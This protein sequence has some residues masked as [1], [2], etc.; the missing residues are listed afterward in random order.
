MEV[1]ADSVG[2]MLLVAMGAET[3]GAGDCVCAPLLADAALD[4]ESSAEG[5]STAAVGLADAVPL[6]ASEASALGLC[7]AA[8]LPEPPCA[9]D[10]VAAALTEPPAA[11]LGVA[12][13]DCEVDAHELAEPRALPAA[14]LLS[15]GLELAK[16]VALSSAASE[17][18]LLADIVARATLF[19][20][21]TLAVCAALPVPAA[22]ALAV[23]VKIGEAVS[24]TLEEAEPLTSAVAERELAAGG[25]GDGFVEADCAGA[26][27]EGDCDAA[28]GEPDVDAVAESSPELAE[29]DDDALASAAVPVA[30]AE[31]DRAA[32]EVCEPAAVAL[33]LSVGAGEMLCGS[34]WDAEKVAAGAVAVRAAEVS[35]EAVAAVG[36]SVAGADGEELGER[37]AGAEAESWEVPVAAPAGGDAEVR[38]ELDARRGESLGDCVFPVG[39]NVAGALANPLI[40]AALGVKV[41]AST[42]LV[43]AEAV[44]DAEPRALTLPQPLADAEAGTGVGDAVTRAGVAEAA[45]DVDG[46]VD[47]DALALASADSEPAAEGDGAPPDALAFALPL[48]ST[49]LCD[50][51][52]ECEGTGE[53]VPAALGEAAP[54]SDCVGAALALSPAALAEAAP[55]GLCVPPRAPE[56]DG[57]LLALP[58][59]PP[60][61]PPLS[62]GGADS[63]GEALPGPLRLSCAEADAQPLGFATDADGERLREGQPD[64]DA[65]VEG[66]R[67]ERTLPLVAPLPVKGPVAVRGCEAPGDAVIED[68]DCVETDG[69]ALA[70]GDF[71]GETDARAEAVSEGLL[72]AEAVGASNVA[73]A[74]AC[75]ELRGED[76]CAVEGDVLPLAPADGDDDGE[77]AA[78]EEL[79]PALAEIEAPSDGLG[80][81]VP[82]PRGEEV[83]RSTEPVACAEPEDCVSGDA[84]AGKPEG[85]RGAL[86]VGAAD[87]ECAFDALPDGV[88][89]GEGLLESDGDGVSD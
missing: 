32:L 71:D 57:V 47:A 67:E 56:P 27:A 59:S 64:G 24:C 79:P 36:E 34:D 20:A 81:C 39:E 33:T 74:V 41:G 10:G 65:E 69:D 15:S 37:V 48:G 23:P 82:E 72:E 6:L 26:L 78:G 73:E 77:T 52:G 62:V 38:G 31:K 53:P 63:D 66:E 51:C 19:V 22:E 29:A 1:C 85:D 43:G 5:D 8:A 21:L 87:G 44:T 11:A 18:E 75:T 14:L 49:P 46:E 13:D 88:G 76:E 60:A 84:E 12:A 7:V 2:G 68:D 86:G 54:A 89:Q 58:L 25:D 40:E 70:R 4:A 35:A 17:G 42:V 45:A 3:V 50:D 28:P 16:K 55:A 80:T 61:P 9:A 30:A 83:A